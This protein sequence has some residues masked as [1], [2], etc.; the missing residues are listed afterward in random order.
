MNETATAFCYDVPLK[1]A[2]TGFK[3]IPMIGIS[4]NSLSPRL[5]LCGE[6]FIHKVILSKRHRYA[7]VESVDVTGGL[8]GR[9]LVV[10]FRN[11]IFTFAARL[12]DER[13]LKGVANYFQTRGVELT[14]GARA[15]VADDF[16][17]AS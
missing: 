1:I 14:N 4:H 7:E 11:S 9:Q 16:S 10:K 12:R 2:F 5:Q 6:D 13:E 15:F 17:S 8:L 3:K